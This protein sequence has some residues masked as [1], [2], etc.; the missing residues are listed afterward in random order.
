VNRNMK[1]AKKVALM[2]Y[3]ASLGSD[4]SAIFQYG[5][6]HARIALDQIEDVVER[7]VRLID[8]S[9]HKEHIYGE[10]GDLI[11]NMRELMGRLEE[12][13]AIIAYA[14][15]KVDEKHLRNKFPNHIRDEIDFTVKKDK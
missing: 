4:L 8:E 12:G 2:T 13:L 5:S 6:S 15:S 7:A 14:S 3:T 9:E 10:A 11:V 1:L